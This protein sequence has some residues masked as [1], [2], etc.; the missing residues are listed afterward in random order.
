MDDSKLTAAHRACVDNADFD[1]DEV[2]FT[3]LRERVDRFDDGSDPT[4]H[5]NTLLGRNIVAF[6]K[7][8]LINYSITSTRQDLSKPSIRAGTTYY[9]RYSWY[10]SDS[11][12][13]IIKLYVDRMDIINMIDDNITNLTDYITQLNDGVD[14]YNDMLHDPRHSHPNEISRINNEIRI[15][16]NQIEEAQST[17][18][19]IQQLKGKVERLGGWGKPSFDHLMDIICELEDKLYM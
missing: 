11:I 4:R 10:V 12:E 16:L 17:L 8:S 18:P 3:A 15:M 19:D 7:Q 9:W 6:N 1:H 13:R 5:N 2:F 14:M